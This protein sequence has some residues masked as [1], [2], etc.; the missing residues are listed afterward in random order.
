METTSDMTRDGIPMASSITPDPHQSN[1]RE[2]WTLVNRNL[3]GL[4]L[5]TINFLVILKE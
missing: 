5:L 1:I 2:P 3:R 4:I